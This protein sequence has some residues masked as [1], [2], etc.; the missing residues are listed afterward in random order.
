MQQNRPFFFRLGI[1]FRFGQTV[2]PQPATFQMMLE[3]IVDR[4]RFRIIFRPK[5]LKFFFRHFLFLKQQY[6]SVNDTTQTENCPQNVL[7][8][9]FS[10]F[11]D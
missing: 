5:S 7:A 2:N 4:R 6:D 10:F 8:G 9:S 11:Q 1:A 3:K